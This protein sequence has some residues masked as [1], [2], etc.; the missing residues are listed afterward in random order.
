MK[1]L[2]LI[3]EKKMKYFNKGILLFVAVNIV[4][5]LLAC[6]TFSCSPSL[7]LLHMIGTAVAVYS[8]LLSLLAVI[9]GFHYLITGE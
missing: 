6:I 4:A 5:L 7:Y 8:T 2:D 1:E 3:K 9:F